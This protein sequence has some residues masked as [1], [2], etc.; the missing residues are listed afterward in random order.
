MTLPVSGGAIPK[1]ILVVDDDVMVLKFVCTI[2]ETKGYSILRA[3]GPLEA[4]N[5]E[6]DHVGEIDLLLSDF[7]MPDMNGIQLATKITEHRPGIRVAF[8]SGYADGPLLLLNN[9]WKLVKK[10]FVIEGLLE[11]VREVLHGPPPKALDH[12]DTRTA[13]PTGF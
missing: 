9:G 10:P 12:F 7:T 6:S 11:L 4:L 3:P 8:M 2:L 1:T 5:L 13:T